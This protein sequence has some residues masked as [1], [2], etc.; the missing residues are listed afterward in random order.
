MT[1]ERRKNYYRP[2][3]DSDAKLASLNVS[4]LFSDFHTDFLAD[5]TGIPAKTL[6]SWKSR[7]T[8]SATVATEICK[9]EEVSAAG[10]T[11]EKLRPDILTW[12]DEQ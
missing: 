7:G 6:R 12:F 4:R 5:E 8:V 10:Y 1:E 2:I 3:L 11:R 9:V